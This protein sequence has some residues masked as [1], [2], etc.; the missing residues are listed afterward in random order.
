MKA[1]FKRHVRTVIAAIAV[2]TV[3]TAA[4]FFAESPKNSSNSSPD[5]KESLAPSAQSSTESKASLS[6]EEILQSIV[7]SDP[8]QPSQTEQQSSFAETST[9]GQTSQTEQQSSF[10]ETS[11]H[12]QPSHTEQQSSYG[13]TSPDDSRQDS[14]VPTDPETLHCTFKIECP[15]LLSN[16][17]SL[18]KNKRSLVPSDGII[19]PKQNTTAKKGESVFD[20]TKR[21]C[22]ENG[23]PFEFTLTPVYNTAY[24]E[25]IYNLYE[26]DCGSASGWVYSVNGV[27]P[28]VGCSDV[29]LSDGDSIVW[30]YTCQLGNDITFR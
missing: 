23:I 13:E 3:L 24:I 2:L 6:D 1:F 30:H 7:P 9:H 5:K 20:L 16:M 15:V 18:K 12:G 25:G 4:F 17:D 11:T 29:K 14:S 27:L 8:G 28:S 22:R 19:L 21:V 26:F 10:A